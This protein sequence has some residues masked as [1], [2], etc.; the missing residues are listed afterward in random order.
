[1]IGYGL[2]V[3]ANLNIKRANLT[4]KRHHVMSTFSGEGLGRQ[5]GEVQRIPSL[6]T[7]LGRPRERRATLTWDRIKKLR[8]QTQPQ[9][10]AEDHLATLWSIIV[11][12]KGSISTGVSFCQLLS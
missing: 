4:T 11:W 3:R 5:E 1:M 8:P 10:Q 6:A 12:I 2:F 9:W 7:Y